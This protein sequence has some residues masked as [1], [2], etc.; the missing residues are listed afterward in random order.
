MDLN[1]LQTLLETDVSPVGVLSGANFKIQDVDW[2]FKSVTII[3]KGGRKG[4]NQPPSPPDEDQPNIEI[5]DPPDDE[6]GGDEDNEGSG[7]DN[8]SQEI[9]IGSIIQDF[10]TGQYG[11]VTNIHPNGDIDWIP[12]DE[13]ELRREGFIA[14]MKLDRSNLDGFIG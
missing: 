4:P 11:K 7:D 8:T 5:I 14:S 9:K 1:K 2:D 10:K 6:G 3:T 13:D 12:A